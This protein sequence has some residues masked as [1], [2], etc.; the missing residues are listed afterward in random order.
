MGKD[1]VNQIFNSCCLSGMKELP[2]NSI[3]CCVT[4][5]PYYNL[6]D[7][8]VDGQIELKRSP[9]EYVQKLVEV[10]MEVKRVLKPEGTFW[11]NIGDSYAGSGHGYLTERQ[12]GD[13]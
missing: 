3:D 7:Y 6:R 13:K 4:S 8:G 12:T 1:F 10:F 2:D 5:P 9:S 11:L